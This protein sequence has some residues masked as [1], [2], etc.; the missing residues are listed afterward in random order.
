MPHPGV[1]SLQLLLVSPRS[2]DAP[3]IQNLQ[4]QDIFLLLVAL[5]AGFGR[6]RLIP[7]SR[8]RFSEGQGED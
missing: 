5:P 2:G 3:A 6:A 4:I 1:V 7:G 8:G